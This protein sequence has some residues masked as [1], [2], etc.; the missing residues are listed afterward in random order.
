MI[1]SSALA[2][3]PAVP[4]AANDNRG[5]AR[6]LLRLVTSADNNVHT[7]TD[8]VTAANSQTLT[9]DAIDRLKTATGSYGTVSA[10]T[11]DS[12]VNMLA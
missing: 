7:I 3:T 12:N 9:Y 5:G 1:A 2:K 11:Y 6:D 4:S 8:A 10:I